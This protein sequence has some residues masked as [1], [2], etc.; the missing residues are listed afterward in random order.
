LNVNAQSEVDYYAAQTASGTPLQALGLFVAIIMALGS[1][2][3]VMNTMYGAVARRGKELGTLR[4]LGFSS[5]SVLTGVLAE[6]L[7]I[8]LLGGLAGCLLVLPLN[9]L[10]TSVGNF[11]TL[12]EVGFTFAV[13]ARA[14][15]VGLLFALVMGSLG[16][17]LP[18]RMA[19]RKT[20]LA[21][22][23]DL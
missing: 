3:A 16:G 18:A 17:L 13:D 12:S 4:V 7:T 23:R 1:S 11:V 21:A 10:T 8:A 19:A 5:R 22:L 9:T 20:I 2:C 6:S 14:M 15:T